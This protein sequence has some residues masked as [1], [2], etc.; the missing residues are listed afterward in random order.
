[1]GVDSAALI[2]ILVLAAFPSMAQ[3][4]EK[5]HQVKHRRTKLMFNADVDGVLMAS[6]RTLPRPASNGLTMRVSLLKF[7]KSCTT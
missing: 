3:T 5:S 6:V 7:E 2:L 4:D 1:M